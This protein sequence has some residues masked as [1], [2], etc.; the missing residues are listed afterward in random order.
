MAAQLRQLPGADAY[1]AKF[2]Q[3]LADC[4]AAPTSVRSWSRRTPSS[5]TPVWA[6]AGKGC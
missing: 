5:P 3:W 2:A 6:G 1:R 4:G